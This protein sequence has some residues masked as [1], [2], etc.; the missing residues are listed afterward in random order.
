M[1]ESERHW[2]RFSA[3]RDGKALSC[4]KQG[5]NSIGLSIYKITVNALR[6]MESGREEKQGDQVEGIRTKADGR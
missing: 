2:F 4:F 1:T 5:S 3:K 6:R